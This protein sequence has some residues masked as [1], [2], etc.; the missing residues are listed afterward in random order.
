MAQWWPVKDCSRLFAGRPVTALTVVRGLGVYP[1]VLEQ[2]QPPAEQG[3][4]RALYHWI[5]FLRN[6]NEGNKS[7]HRETNI[8]LT[9]NSAFSLIFSVG[10]NFP[11]CLNDLSGFKRYQVIY[12]FAHK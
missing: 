4:Q 5:I 7:A 12:H 11:S 10:T 2:H 9:V 3:G 6:T 1:G 8:H